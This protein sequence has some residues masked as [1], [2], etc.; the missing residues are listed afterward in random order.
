M[1]HF[2]F[3]IPIFLIL[4]SLVIILFGRLLPKNGGYLSLFTTGLSFLAIGIVAGRVISG[5]IVLPVHQQF[6]WFMMDFYPVGMGLMLDG[7]SLMLLFVITG[8][9]FCIQ[10][11][12]LGYIH[13]EFVLKRYYAVSTLTTALLAATVIVHSLFLF[14]ML[15]I[16]IS[17]CSY[18]IITFW[19]DKTASIKGGFTGF[20]VTFIGDMCLL[21]AI[22]M[23][24]VW[25]G[26]FN[27]GQINHHIRAGYITAPMLE[28]LAALA[29][30]AIISKAALM[31][32]HFW[33]HGAMEGPIP[34]TAF[35]HGTMMAN[36]S[37]YLM[38]RFQ[39]L[40]SSA[41]YTQ[42]IFTW[43]VAVSI[44]MM[45]VFALSAVDIKTILAFSTIS[46][47]GYMLLVLRYGGT[48]PAVFHL[49]IHSAV[50]VLLFLAAGSVLFVLH[51]RDIRQ[52][53][54]LAKRMPVTAILFFSGIVSLS[55]I[56]PFSGFFSKHASILYICTGSSPL[57]CGII[58]TTVFITS[59][60]IFRLW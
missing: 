36:I 23:L 47:A 8:I 12:S 4:C 37:V 9:G 58:L 27:L 41:P 32:L 60:Y 5:D 46:E 6:R 30:M 50:K 19:S 55:G 29:A 38:L 56:P 45:S 54:G 33:V 3:F 28:T 53:G 14:A 43:V 17:L 48:A 49:F 25:L 44:L 10:V 20:M 35:L 15:W 11:Y 40:F 34:L 13:D 31:P 39:F 57:I 59:I 52:M 18:L 51:T 7:I 42:A 21:I 24:F 26:T 2:I 22:I 16:G 1:I